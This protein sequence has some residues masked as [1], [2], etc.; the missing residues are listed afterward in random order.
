MS[1]TTN[2]HVSESS[3][4]PLTSWFPENEVD[5]SAVRRQLAKI[6]ESPLF[7]NSRRCAKL[8]QFTVE[9]VLENRT[10]QLK[11]RSLGVEVFQREPDY[12]TNRDPVVRTTAVEIRKRLAQYYQEPRHAREI[13]ISFPS[14][15]YV[16][17]FRLPDGRN[18]SDLAGKD[19]APT[20]VRKVSD[21]I[22]IRRRWVLWTVAA[23]MIAAMASALWYR[24]SQQMTAL[25]RFWNPLITSPGAVS[26]VI[27]GAG[28]ASSSAES[29]PVSVLDLQRE[30]RVAFA[31]ASTLSRITGMMML[32][33]KPFHIRRHQIAKLDDLR[34]GPV[35]LIGAFNNT[36]T[37]RLIEHGRYRFVR[38]SQA[39]E[40]WIADEM[41]P[42]NRSWLVHEAEPY[43]DL[44][45]DYALVSRILDPTTG[46]FVVTAAG[47]TKF[48]T[49]AAGEFLTE[50]GYMESAVRSA[51]PDWDRKNFQIVIATHPVGESSGPPRV[52]ATYFW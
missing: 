36:W 38:D 10:D 7:A 8:L 25:D 47:I 15:T 39:H 24:H 16:P 9:S 34:D 2:G 21:A 42:G 14:G 17:E 13:R 33:G 48:G 29:V 45:E 35:V 11:E 40:G 3:H 31:D 19:T 37:I 1:A 49:A 43:Q 26:L 28:P 6:L 51:P 32:K 5:R 12:D 41:N 4:E 44:R 22:I 18:P 27:G 50:P 23:M 20:G 52:I 46:R 30:E